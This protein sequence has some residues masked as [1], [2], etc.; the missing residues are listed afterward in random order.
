[1][2]LQLLLRIALSTAVLSV[3]GVGVASSAESTT[4]GQAGA[5]TTCDT[6]G[7]LIAAQTGTSGGVSYTVPGGRWR[8]TSWQA[9]GSPTGRLALVVYRPTGNTDEYTVVGRTEAHRL[10]KAKNHFSADIAVKG[11]DL[12]GFWSK[13]GTMCALATESSSD[14]ASIYFPADLP[15]PGTSLTLIPGF[16]VGYRLNMQVNLI[17][18]A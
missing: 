2:R 9:A 14:T 6:P 12:I 4:L 5:D 17:Q 3:V 16:A 8:I 10:P 18:K 1:M 7:D 11:G 15:S 13:A